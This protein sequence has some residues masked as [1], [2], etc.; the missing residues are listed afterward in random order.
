MLPAAAGLAGKK[1]LVVD[2]DF[3]NIFAITALL[4]RAEIEVISAESGREGIAILGRTAD[5]DFVLVD[6]MMP[7]V[8]G[9]DTMRAMRKLSGR[10]RVPIVALTAKTGNGER[11]RCIE[12][13]ASAYIPKPLEANLLL[14]FLKGQWLDA[15]VTEGAI[16]EVLV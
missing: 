5:I 6:T 7:I 2:D 8:N 11:E 3:R 13:G 14:L 10:A 4:E 9:Y 15:G 16:S 1:V 12:A